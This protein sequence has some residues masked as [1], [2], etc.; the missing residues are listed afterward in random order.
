MPI[1]ALGDLEPDIHPDAYVHPDAVVIGQVTIGEGSSIWPHAVIRADDAPITIGA[2][3]SIQD[4][5]IVHTTPPTPTWVGD[6]CVVGHAAHL[7][8]CRIEHGALVGSGS[9][10]LHAAVVGTGSI[11]GANAVVTNGME[12]PPH[13]MALGV[14]AK[15]RPAPEHQDTMIIFN[16]ANYV[17]RGEWYRKELR[18]LD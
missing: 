4:G 15:I 6:D 18:R 7:E 9:I 8:G 1:Y 12:V 14:P 17:Q 11:V 3:T 2:R 5:T 10:V 13:S 16:A